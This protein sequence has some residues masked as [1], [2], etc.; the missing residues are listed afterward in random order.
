MAGRQDPLCAAAHTE[1]FDRKLAR[2]AKLSLH[3]GVASDA[4]E[5]QGVVR[6]LHYV[7]PPGTSGGSSHLGLPLGV[8][9]RPIVQTIYGRR[10]QAFSV[11]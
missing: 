1:S 3:T 11:R 7:M 10:Q 6:L 8:V 9:T 4:H 5:R 2:A